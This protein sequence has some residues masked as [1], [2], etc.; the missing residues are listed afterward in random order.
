VTVAAVLSS[1]APL[2]AVPLGILFL[3]ER[4]S[5]TAALG[6]V[7]TVIGIVVLEL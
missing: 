2:F 6:A 3:G 7:V 4:L 5:P 1:T